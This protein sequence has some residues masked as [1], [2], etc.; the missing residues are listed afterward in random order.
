MENQSWLDTVSMLRALLR[1]HR[2]NEAWALIERLPTERLD[3]AEILVCR[4]RLLQIL[5]QEAVDEPLAAARESLAHA[6]ALSPEAIEPRTEMGHFL[7]AVLNRPADALEQFELAEQLAR[8]SLKNALIGKLK[9]MAQLGRGDAA[10]SEL[11][12]LGPV[13]PDDTELGL[14][15]IEL[16][17]EESGE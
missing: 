14:L 12:A 2:F 17:D 3:S 15:R 7:F 6:C 4:A 1:E 16:E 8:N 11:A 9:C 5:P 13:F 10:R